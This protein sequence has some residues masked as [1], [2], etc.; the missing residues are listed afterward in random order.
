MKAT[1]IKQIKFNRGQVSDLLSERL[2][3]GL[4]NACGTV[5][6]NIYINRYGQIQNAPNCVFSADTFAASGTD[7]LNGPCEILG[8]FDTGTDTVFAIGLCGTDNSLCV[9]G[10]LSKTAPYKKIALNAPLARKVLSNIVAFPDDIKMYQFGYNVVLYGQQNKPILFNITPHVSDG[11]I[12]PQL[13]VKEDY[14]NNAFDNI[15][16]RGINTGVPS[17]FTVP[18][19]SYYIIGSSQT[20][21]TTKKIVEIHRNNAGGAFTQSLVGQMIN[22]PANSGVLQVRSVEDA[23]TLTAYIITPFIALSTGAQTINIP[24]GGADSASWVFGYENPFGKFEIPGQ[25]GS[26]IYSYPDS[27]IYV[28]QRLVFGGNDYHG[29]LICASRV[30]VLSDFDSE[31]GTESDAFTTAIASKDFCRIV[32]FVVSNNE[33][34]IAC[35]NGEYAMSLANL[36]PTGSLKGFDLR[37]EVG[38]TNNSAICDC[39]GLT[40]YVSND[41]TAIYGTQFNFLRDRYQPI[42]LTSQ[43]DNIIH[44]CI[45]LR[46]LTNRPNSETNCLVGLNND[47]SICVGSID[48]NAGLV[49]FSRFLNRQYHVK[50][51]NNPTRTYSLAKILAV[52][53]CLWGVLKI[54]NGLPPSNNMLVRFVMNEIFDLPC[55]VKTSGAHID[56]LTISSIQNG[57]AKIDDMRAL[58]YNSTTGNYEIIKPV[59]KTDNGDNTFTIN[60]AND[61]TVTNIVVA[62]FPRQSDWRSVEIGLGLATRELNKRIVK[63]EGVIEPMQVTGAGRFAGLVLTPDQAKNFISLTRSK[64]VVAMDIDNLGNTSYVENT[65]VMWRRAF[66]NPSREMHYGVSMLA[67]FLVKSITATVEYDEAA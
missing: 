6:D 5:Y 18:T 11:W 55:W 44:D 39:G 37:S 4:Q 66:D 23:D 14:F 28:N 52:G 43:T 65:D 16:V 61:I 48:L 1:T 31:T 30:G 41:K 42:S 32:D 58:Y 26:Y 9:F 21:I 47:A 56:T 50:F 60:F 24:W 64:E 38:I 29:N 17:D 46:Y 63:L 34:R 10:G 25:G 49:A 13:T 20:Q 57:F 59:S 12:A 2:D 15:Y 45:S 3:M 53:N 33:L 8:L 54:K 27:V 40:A 51:G 36:T 22:S 67:P 19:S 7:I 62:G 35:T